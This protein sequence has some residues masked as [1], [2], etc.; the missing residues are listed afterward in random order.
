MQIDIKDMKALPI[1]THLFTILHL[2]DPPLSSIKA[3]SAHGAHESRGSNWGE[4]DTERETDREQPFSE[5]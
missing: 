3:Q 1:N 4:G 5:D 2:E